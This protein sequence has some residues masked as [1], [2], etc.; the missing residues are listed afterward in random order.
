LLGEAS[1]AAVTIGDLVLAGPHH[2]A[3]LAE[4]GPPIDGI[5]GAALSRRRVVWLDFAS[6]RLR[7]LPPADFHPPRD[8]EA[9]AF[10]RR[11]DWAG[12]LGGHIILDGRRQKAYRLP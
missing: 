11:P 8:A 4:P 6:H 2:S 5:I 9:I 10:P 12:G 1:F 7:L 3:P